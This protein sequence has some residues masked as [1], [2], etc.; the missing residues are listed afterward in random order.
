MISLKQIQYALAVERE[1]QFKKAAE[2]CAISQSAL[3]TALA[4]MEKQLGFQVF[5]RDN[6]KV[7]IT[8]LGQQVLNIARTI[9]IQLGDIHKLAETRKGPLSTPLTL[10]VIPTIAPFLLPRVLPS[11]QTQYPMLELSI[12]EDQ[13]AQ[14]IDLVKRGTLDSAILALPYPCKGLLTFSFWEENLHWITSADDPCAQQA[15]VD[16]ATLRDARLMLLKDGHCLS[17]HALAAC[18]L[19]DASTQRFSATSL[20][21][22]IQLVAGNIGTTLVPAMALE[23]LVTPNPL[24]ASVPLSEPGPHRSIAFVVRPNYPNLENIERLKTLFQSQL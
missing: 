2:E 12:I 3:S 22:L 24:L 16:S 11:L 18:Q 13:S 15:C 23:Q 7:L 6:R 21:T 5:E 1:L 14:L 9:E 20:S 4:E 17:D 10:G 19:N 8:P